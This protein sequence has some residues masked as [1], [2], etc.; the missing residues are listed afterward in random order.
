MKGGSLGEV[1]IFLAFIDVC[2]RQNGLKAR[3]H[4]W[5]FPGTQ[6]RHRRRE[7]QL[8]SRPS[9][10]QPPE[11]SLGPEH[12]FGGGGWGQE[13]IFISKLGRKGPGGTKQCTAKRTSQ[14]VKDSTFRGSTTDTDQR[15]EMR[16]ISDVFLQRSVINL[17]RAHFRIRL[18]PVLYL[19][20]NAETL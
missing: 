17:S 15:P 5:P 9:R 16:W 10:V 2:V 14:V 4:P 8:W 11:P 7:A 3:S 12:L 1:F 19:D 20:W 6:K 13:L 18:F